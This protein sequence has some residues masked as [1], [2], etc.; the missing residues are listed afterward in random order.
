MKD[1]TSH[2][3]A[4]IEL[5][6]LAACGPGCTAEYFVLPNSVVFGGVVDVVSANG[7]SH[8]SHLVVGT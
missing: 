4:G 5:L 3:T 8:E 7:L 1:Y 6:D 2:P